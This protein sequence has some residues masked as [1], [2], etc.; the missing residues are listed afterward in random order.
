GR[1]RRWWHRSL[2]LAGLGMVGYCGVIVVLLLLENWLL[3]H[4]TQ[5][6]QDWQGP[7]NAQVQDVVLHSADGV[8]LHAWWCPTPQRRPGQGV[9]LYCHGNAGNLSYRA[10]A[11]ARWQQ[12]LEMPVLIFD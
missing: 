5:A 10:E 8:R 4:P 6:A 3:F 12:Q 11:I 9:M 7:P 1:R 2:R